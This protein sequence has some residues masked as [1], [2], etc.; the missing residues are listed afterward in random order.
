MR[1]VTSVAHVA[2][3]LV[4]RSVPVR[5]VLALALSAHPARRGPALVRKRQRA[6]RARGLCDGDR[7]SG[8]LA[9]AV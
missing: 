5:L 7:L 3:V 9:G 8:G 6:G 4:W 1:S 2:L